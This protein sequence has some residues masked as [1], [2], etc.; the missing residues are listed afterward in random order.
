MIFFFFMILIFKKVFRRLQWLRS[1]TNPSVGWLFCC[2]P[3]ATTLFLKMRFSLG[4]QCL[5]DHLESDG[6][7]IVICIFHHR[8]PPFVV[9]RFSYFTFAFFRNLSIRFL[10]R[11]KTLKRRCSARCWASNEPLTLSF[12]FSSLQILVSFFKTLLFCLIISALII[13][14]TV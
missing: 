6:G 14:A 8:A 3:S 13:N 2:A 4:P 11:S 12:W 9:C 10:C 7:R 1:L 5:E